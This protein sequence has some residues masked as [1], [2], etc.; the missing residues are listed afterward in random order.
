MANLAEVLRHKKQ[1]LLK[2]YEKLGADADHWNKMVRELYRQIQEWLAPLAQDGLLSFEQHAVDYEIPLVGVR[3]SESLSIKFFN[4]ET[5]EFK[6]GGMRIGGMFGRIDMR[7][8]L[9][10]ARIILPHPQGPWQLAERRY[11]RGEMEVYEFT[12]ENFEKIVISYV[13][14]F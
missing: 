4:H 1:E 13:E 5:I 12:Q 2:M 9:R 6:D 11:T 14:N 7:F 8:G 10:H 3:Y